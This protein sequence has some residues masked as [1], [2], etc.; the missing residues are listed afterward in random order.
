MG[1]CKTDKAEPAFALT[2][3]LSETSR[4][5]NVEVASQMMRHRFAKRIHLGEIEVKRGVDNGETMRIVL[6]Q[7]DILPCPKC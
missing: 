4:E 5:W 7:D 6:V 1:C 2:R 3:R